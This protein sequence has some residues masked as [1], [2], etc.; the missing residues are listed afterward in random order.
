MVKKKGESR[1]R[2]VRC[3]TCGTL[4]HR[5]DKTHWMGGKVPAS[6]IFADI[7]HHYKTQHPKKFRESIRKGVEARRK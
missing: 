5:Y 7:R 6:V 3:R 4:I 1:Y 2:N